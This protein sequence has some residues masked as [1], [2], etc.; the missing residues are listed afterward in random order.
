MAARVKRAKRARPRKRPGSISK[1]F[2]NRWP[3]TCAGC[4][5]YIP[6]DTLV[7][8]DQFDQLVHDNCVMPDEYGRP[9]VL[10]AWRPELSEA[11][12]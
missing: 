8:F 5:E 2:P 9:A 1:T 6:V 3:T 4:G 10:D 11:Q 7:C 12:G